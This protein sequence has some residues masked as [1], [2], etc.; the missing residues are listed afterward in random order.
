M[1]LNDIRYSVLS[2]YPRGDGK[3]SISKHTKINNAAAALH[4]GLLQENRLCS[5][6][7]VHVNICSEEMGTELAINKVIMIIN[8]VHL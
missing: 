6:C 8:A 2:L 7:T 1:I 4:L 3:I 5:K